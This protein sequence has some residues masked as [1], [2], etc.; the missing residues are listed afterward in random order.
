MLFDL[1]ALLGLGLQQEAAPL[2]PGDGLVTV[3]ILQL[4][5]TMSHKPCFCV[6]HACAVR[7]RHIMC[8]QQ[9][10]PKF[11]SLSICRLGRKGTHTC[12]CQAGV[13]TAQTS[14]H[15]KSAASAAPMMQSQ[16]CSISRIFA[17]WLRQS[18]LRMSAPSQRHTHLQVP[19]WSADGTD[20]HAP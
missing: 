15:H 9:N 14:T 3:R 8:Q 13:P 2:S 19:G 12:K 4:L 7:M 11:Y 18:E 20:E 6:C 16:A 10:K 1:A 5:R 17:C